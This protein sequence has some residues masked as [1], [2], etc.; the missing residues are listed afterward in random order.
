MALLAVLVLGTSLCCLAALLARNRLNRRH[1]VDPAVATDAPLTWLVDPRAPARLHRRLARVGTTASLVADDHRPR[2][3]RRR[4][5][6]PPSPLAATADDLLAQAV[7]LDRQVTRLGMLSSSARRRPLAE[8]GRSI[9]ELEVAGARLV[10][11]STQVR[12]PQGLDTDDPVLTD[13][14]RR[15]DHLADAHQELVDLDAETRLVAHPLPAPPAAAA[16]PAPPA[17][18]PAP[19][20]AA[21]PTTPQ[22]QTWPPTAPGT[23]R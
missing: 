9:D 20:A 19:P 16:R 15:I 14:A 22:P 17:A 8:L 5:A 18:R 3:R 21:A 12:A 11:L 1:R 10:G 13:I 2:P 23:R 6:D 7:V 4:R